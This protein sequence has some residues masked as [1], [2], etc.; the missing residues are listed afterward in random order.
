MDNLEAARGYAQSG[1][2]VFPLAQGGKTPIVANGFK[3]ATRK[4]GV[5]DQWWEHWPAAN[6]GV[7]LGR[8]GLVVVDVD[9]WKAVGE[10]TRLGFLLPR[11]LSQTTP[12]GGAHYVYQAPTWELRNTTR[13]LQGVGPTPGIDLRAN[14]GY[15]LVDPGVVNGN[16]YQWLGSLWADEPAPCPDWLREPEPMVLG[17]V[18]PVGDRYIEAALEGE[19]R[20]VAAA[21]EGTRNDQLVRSAFSIGQLI[22]AGLDLHTASNRLVIAAFRC[23]LDDRETRRTIASGID[24]GYR[25]PRR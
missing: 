2:F 10:L 3:R 19:C 24:A 5:I 11:T 15:I 25:N 16:R 6:I 23:G 8:T 20:K 17:P 9:D 18:V 4:L 12:R 1:W 21:P 22:H 7:D 13:R 14:G